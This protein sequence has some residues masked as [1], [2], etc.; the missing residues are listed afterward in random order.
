[1]QHVYYIAV[2][3]MVY[4]VKRISD[5]YDFKQLMKLLLN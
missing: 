2:C 3:F 5:I 4:Y 1:M